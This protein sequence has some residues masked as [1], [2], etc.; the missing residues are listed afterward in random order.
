MLKTTIFFSIFLSGLCSFSQI[1][2]EKI[3][4]DTIFETVKV[5]YKPIDRSTYFYK[6]IA[7]FADDTSQIAIEKTYTNQQKNGIYKAYYPNGK[8]KI[9]TVYGND[10]IHGEWTYFNSDGIIITKGVYKEGVKFGYWAYKSRRIYG[11]YKKG[12]KH[13]KWKRFRKNEKNNKT[14]K[15]YVSHYKHGKLTGG[16]GFGNEKPIILYKG[17]SVNESTIPLYD[18]KEISKEYQQ[19]ISFL[20]ENTVFRRAIKGK[21]GGSIKKYFKDEKF[22]FGLSSSLLPL[23]ISSFIEESKAEKILVSKIDSILKN[24]PDSLKLSFSDV[25]IEKNEALYKCSTDSTS[26]MWVFFSR[27]NNNLMRID[28]VKYDKHV[29]NKDTPISYKEVEDRKKFKILLYFDDNKVLTGAEYEK[30]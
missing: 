17:D 22:S 6:K 4:I 15:K 5:I 24:N 7:V 19:A 14:E 25:V 30:R 18:E 2:D 9:K 28:V 13:K 12:L 8:L 1:V 23:D 11:R 10:K 3:Q 26:L 29:E 21:F 16:E 27:V 20:T